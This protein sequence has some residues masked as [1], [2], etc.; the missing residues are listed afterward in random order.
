[1]LES[2][3]ELATAPFLT[4]TKTITDIHKTV[5]VRVRA[6]VRACVL[7]CVCECNGWNKHLN[8]I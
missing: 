6:D 7:A 8:K 1:M 3:L 4:L 5:R 2:F